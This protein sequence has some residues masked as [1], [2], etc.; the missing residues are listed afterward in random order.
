MKTKINEKKFSEK[1]TSYDNDN[2]Y[3]IYFIDSKVLYYNSNY[4]KVEGR[5]L[6]VQFLKG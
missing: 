4:R 2:V 6:L 5:A 3:A 1:S